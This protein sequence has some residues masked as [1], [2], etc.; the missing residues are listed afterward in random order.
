MATIG[1]ASCVIYVRMS[2]DRSGEEL[3]VERHEKDCRKLAKKLNLNVEHVYS[4]NDQS[5]TTG[6]PRPGFEAML[7]A[8]PKAIVAWHQDRLLRL[9]KD[10][11]RVIDVGVPVYFVTSAENGLDLSSPAGRAVARTVAAWSQYEGE[12]KRLRQISKNQ[13]LAEHGHWQFSLRPYGYQRVNGTIV[14]VPEEAEIILEGY[15]RVLKGASYRELAMDWNRRGIKPL[16][17]EQ[18]KGSRVQRM[19]ENS[20]YGGI[21][22]YKDEEVDLDEGKKIQW[23][24]ILTPR[25]WK[26]FRELKLNRKRK[27]SWAVTPKHL[28]SGML[29]CGTCGGQ[30]FTHLQD[31]KARTNTVNAKGHPI[32]VPVFREDGTRAKTT[33]YVCFNKHCASIRG[34]YVDALVRT[35][36]LKKLADERVVKAMRPSDDAL[37]LQNEIADLQR[38]RDDVTE[39]VGEGLMDKAKAREKLA[40]LSERLERAQA[41]LTAIREESPLSDIRLSES[42][43]EKWD[44][45][46]VLEKR[47]IIA[48]LGLQLTIN[49]ASR[50]VRSVDPETGEKYTERAWALRRIAW[51]LPEG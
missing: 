21:S 27:R 24:P 48:D 14:Q 39:L 10:L 12:Q 46:A 6:K 16:L 47:R 1:Q 42:L 33:A 32:R 7:A 19:L 30:M 41:K 36:V 18:W 29:S 9:T 25:Q 2:Q 22:S 37:P 4:D 34:E 11:E 31:L 38:R 23:A 35:V 3:G 50:G 49:P 5:A 26:D 45:L 20:H 44:A 40:D 43:P 28:M 13:Q 8:K 17:G 15:E 51:E